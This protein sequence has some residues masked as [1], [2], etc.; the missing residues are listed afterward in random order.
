MKRLGLN[1]PVW[2]DAGVPET[3]TQIIVEGFTDASLA[4]IYKKMCDMFCVNKM[5]RLFA[6]CP[7]LYLR[8]LKNISIT[9]G[10]ERFSVKTQIT[11]SHFSEER[12]EAG[13]IKVV[14]GIH[15]EGSLRKSEYD[16]ILI[17]IQKDLKEDINIEAVRYSEMFLTEKDTR[18]ISVIAP[19]FREM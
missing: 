6:A 18:T 8:K 17:S 9:N 10:K 16:D 12:I 15:H 19:V 13:G 14:A 4:E 2:E 11:A 5:E 3:G 7:V 1:I